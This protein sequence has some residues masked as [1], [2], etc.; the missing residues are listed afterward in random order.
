MRHTAT[1]EKRVR[2]FLAELEAAD[3]G[4]VTP[5]PLAKDLKDFATL[6]APIGRTGATRQDPAAWVADRNEYVKHFTGTTFVAIGAISKK[7]AQQEAIVCRRLA[8]DSGGYRDEPVEYTHPLCQLFRQVNPIHTQYDLWYQ[9]VA[10]RLMTGDSYWWKAR[11][12]FSVPVELWPLPSQWVWAIPSQEK[13]IAE[14]LVRNVFAKEVYLPADDILH[15]R[16]PNI[17]WNGNGQFYGRPLVTAGAT[18]VD[19]EEQMFKRLYHQFRNFAP[20][21]LHYS[22]DEELGEDE[23]VDLMVQIQAQHAKAE[24]TGTPIF[25][26]S[27]MKVSEFHQSVREMDYSNSLQVVMDYLMAIYAT[28]KAVVGLAKDYNRANVIGATMTWIENTINPLLVHLG[29]HLTQGL[30][31][32]FGED[33][34]VKFQPC[35]VS[36][37]DGLRRDVDVALRAGALTPNEVRE[38]LLELGQYETGGDRPMLPSSLAEAA[39]GNT[40]EPPLVAPSAATT[41]V[42]DEEEP[43]DESTDSESATEDVDE[44]DAVDDMLDVDSEGRLKDAASEVV[45]QFFR[46]RQKNLAER[47]SEDLPCT[48]RVGKATKRKLNGTRV[49]SVF[50]PSAKGD[51]TAF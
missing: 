17:D 1:S 16:E 24:T 12:G 29:Q 48:I 26:H 22:T 15:V 39:I 13:F 7:I 40:T 10:W 25:S 41:P 23:F 43:E 33:L 9:M 50:Q 42:D 8:D 30:A 34:V 2:G 4:Q 3:K 47:F 6:A 20:P 35:T 21:G 45:A 27:G 32:E 11:N 38:V 14:Y 18:A 44:D 37:R 28:P 51:R 31:T 19:L 49:D 36:D 5:S 46:A